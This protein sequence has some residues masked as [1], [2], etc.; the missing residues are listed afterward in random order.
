M[1]ICL[2]VSYSFYDM[3]FLSKDMKA[4][5]N[6]KGES[7]LLVL[8]IIL[9]YLYTFFGK[10]EYHWILITFLMVLSYM[11][12]QN[13]RQNFAYFNDNTS[14]FYSCLT[15]IWLWG[16]FNVII[17]K[18]LEN[19]DYT[20]GYQIYFLGA[21]LIIGL[22]LFETDRRKKLLLKNINNFQNGYEIAIQIR[23]LIKLILNR[24]TNRKLGII[25][26]GYIYH[27]EDSCSNPDC[28]LRKYKDL[29]KSLSKK[30]KGISKAA[31]SDFNLKIVQLEEKLQQC[32]LDHA[33]SMYRASLAKFP[34]N[35]TLRIEYAFFL[36]E[37]L[38]Q[39]DEAIIEWDTA[40]KYRP[41]FV[42]QF[43]IFRQKKLA[44]DE[45]GS[46]AEAGSMDIIAKF[47]FD[48][49]LRQIESEMKRS[50][51]LHFDF[52]LSLKGESPDISRMSDIGLK[53]NKSIV[54]IEEQWNYIQKIN[55]NSP[56][57]LKIYSRFLN[58]IMNDKD[59]AQ[60]YLQRVKE[61]MNGKSN[62][63]DQPGQGHDE[64]FGDVDSLL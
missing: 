30:K 44:Q 53:I 56:R 33:K 31:A 4:L 61:T 10:K 28:N 11:S 49:T 41:G 12:F 63:F 60:E 55:S 19:S 58:S 34:N 52:W 47:A 37:L 26:K 54:Q 17:V 7:F 13:F 36:K 51:Q 57:A 6:N 35:T 42:E 62:H 40:A 24:E 45:G 16:N 5:V 29:F 46:S 59:R 20:G 21:P 22:I 27:H 2:I 32:L 15:G 38:N 18:I 48:S 23:Y 8:K 25:L 50:A 14:K 39:K 9:N 43:V 1:V 3:S 64:N